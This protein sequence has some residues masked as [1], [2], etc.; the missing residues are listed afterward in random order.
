MGLSD[1]IISSSSFHSTCLSSPW[2]S[3]ALCVGIRMY[4]EEAAANEQSSPFS[5]SSSPIL[6]SIFRWGFRSTVKTICFPYNLGV[7]DTQ[8][9]LKLMTTKTAKLLYPKLHLKK[10]THDV[11][12][13]FIAQLLG[14]VSVCEEEIGWVDKEG[15]KFIQTAGG[16]VKVIFQMLCD[17]LL[18]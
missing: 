11:E 6:R 3:T 1:T 2:D 18:M 17:V 16:T 12:L 4:D 9:G 15:S 8:C 13:L 5:I 10:W 14:S 7:Q